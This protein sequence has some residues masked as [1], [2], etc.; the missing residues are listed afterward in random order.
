MIV[1]ADSIQFDWIDYDE[2]GDV[3]YLSVGPPRAVDRSDA[4]PEGPAV[5]YDQGGAV[6]GS[7]D[8][9]SPRSVSSRRYTARVPA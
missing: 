3:L 8:S 4:T 1:R 2:E 9:P 7:R 5:R 6:R